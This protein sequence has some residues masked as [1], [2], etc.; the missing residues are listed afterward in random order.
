MA[1]LE[2]VA[3]L[4]RAN[5]NDLLDQAENPEKLLKQMILDMQ[6]QQVQVKT[7]V[8]LAITDQHLLQKKKQEHDERAVEWRRKAELAI[9]KHHEDVARAALERSVSAKRTADSFHQQLED[10]AVQVENLKSALRKLEAKLAEAEAKA[11]LLLA[12][13]RRARAVD[14]A[15]EA[16]MLSGDSRRQV[17][18]DR[19][20]SQV[21]VAESVSQARAA[22]MGTSVEDR[23]AALERDD[24]VDRL[25][26]ELKA[27]RL[28]S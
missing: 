22:L 9:A 7:Q 5:L 27:G 17:A 20:Q 14:R 11:E 10:Q 13:H 6:N 18:L 15:A 1:L 12:Q 26:A 28:A 25:L 19:L 24:E 21:Q 8:A 23:L 16:G 2:R 3:M 4:L